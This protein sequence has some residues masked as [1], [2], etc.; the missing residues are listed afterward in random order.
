MAKEEYFYG[1]GR[2]FLAPIIAGILGAWRWI[3]DVSSLKRSEE[4]TS[5]LQ[6]R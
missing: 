3:G 5:E 4:H 1:Q 6:S 2:V